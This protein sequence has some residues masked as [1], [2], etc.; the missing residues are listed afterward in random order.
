LLRTQS[1][2][3]NLNQQAEHTKFVRLAEEQSRL[4]EETR[5]KALGAI[6]ELNAVVM[7]LVATRYILDVVTGS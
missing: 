3:A 6:N 5:E 7:N 2:P 1:S 4:A